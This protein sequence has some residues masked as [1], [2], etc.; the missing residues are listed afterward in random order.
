MLFVMLL[1]TYAEQLERERASDNHLSSLNE[2][3]DNSSSE[4]DRMMTRSIG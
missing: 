2:L 4:E 1:D 3:L